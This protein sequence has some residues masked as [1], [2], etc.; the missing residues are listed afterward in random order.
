MLWIR[1]LLLLSLMGIGLVMVLSNPALFPV[2]ILGAPTQPLPLGSLILGSILFG[3]LTGSL[4]LRLL[5]RSPSP[6]TKRS[7]KPRKK[8]M[9]TKQKTKST[10]QKK[11]KSNPTSKARGVSGTD[12][13]EPRAEDWFGSSAKVSGTE[14]ASRSP[15]D[16]YSTPRSPQPSRNP[17]SDRVVD[18]DYRVI[19]PPSVSPPPRKPKDDW[20]D[21]FFED[22]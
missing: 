2:T 8:Q 17:G 21:E 11:V 3:G 4:L 15:R 22:D 7:A 1:L 16:D 19:K 9:R 13:D 14:Y 5:E 18:A 20:D 10:A 6:K 12:W